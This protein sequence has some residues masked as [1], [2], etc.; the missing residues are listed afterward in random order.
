MR[1]ELTAARGALQGAA[2]TRKHLE[3]ARESMEQDKQDLVE[4]LG[5]LRQELAAVREVNQAASRA[6]SPVTLEN[7]ALAAAG[8]VDVASILDKL[9]PPQAAQLAKFA[10]QI[11]ALELQIS[12][13]V[14][15][16]RKMGRVRRSLG[17][18]GR[19]LARLWGSSP[20]MN[21]EEPAEQSS[22]EQHLR[23][24]WTEV[25]C[26]RE[27]MI[28]ITAEAIQADL[29]RQLAEARTQLQAATQRP[30]ELEA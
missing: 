10:Q 14:F 8:V 20:V 9:A 11:E 23:A 28:R 12:K 6:P 16:K 3:S 27:R 15:P 18:L 30:E 21:D 22:T 29:V 26:E 1:R 17:V 24:L 2:E 19:G 5:C 13:H 7:G 25:M 4:Q